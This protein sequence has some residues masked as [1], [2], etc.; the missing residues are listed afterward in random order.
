M[1]ANHLPISHIFK[2]FE[3]EKGEGMCAYDYGKSRFFAK[4]MLQ[5]NR[6]FIRENIGV[7]SESCQMTYIKL[8]VYIS[9]M[10]KGCHPI[11]SLHLYLKYG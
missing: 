6:L 2:I 11:L 1:A 8:L 10:K 4:V 3:H 5:M 9:N 7:Y